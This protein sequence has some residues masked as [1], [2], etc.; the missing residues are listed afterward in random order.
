LHAALDLEDLDDETRAALL[1]LDAEVTAEL[2]A[3]RISA[4]GERIRRDPRLARDF[5]ESEFADADIEFDDDVWRELEHAAFAAIDQRTES[6][7]LGL[8]TPQQIETMPKRRKPI[9]GKG[10]GKKKK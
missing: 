1:L 5:I 9:W 7:L 2:E 4:I 10:E 6:G 3:L 8:L